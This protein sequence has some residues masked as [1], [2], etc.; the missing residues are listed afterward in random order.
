MRKDDRDILH[1]L[2]L[3]LAFLEHGGYRGSP[4]ASPR[5]TILLLDSPICPNFNHPEPT[6]P[7][8]DCRL[9]QFVPPEQKKEACP[10]YHVPL[11]TLGETLDS[12]YRLGTK[13]EREGAL[14]GWLRETIGRIERERFYKKSA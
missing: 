4:R 13:E 8:Q 11:N 10:C 7:C 6:Y 2:K 14:R 3:E 12:L 9:I 5:P 1:L